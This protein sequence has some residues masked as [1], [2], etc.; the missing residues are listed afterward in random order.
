[1]LTDNE[2]ELN[3][4]LFFLFSFF[5]FFSPPLSIPLII[6]AQHAEWSCKLMYSGGEI[7]H[8][9]DQNPTK[10]VQWLVTKNNTKL[11]KRDVVMDKR[12]DLNKTEVQPKISNKQARK[13]LNKNKYTPIITTT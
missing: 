10:V 11:K 5:F 6:H 7:Q 2:K 8:F 12:G 13:K 3:F 4:F 1:M 9:S